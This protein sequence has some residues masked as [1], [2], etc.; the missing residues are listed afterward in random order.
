MTPMNVSILVA[1]IIMMMASEFVVYH[2]DVA[3]RINDG[4]GHIER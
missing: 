2:G 4:F 1:M 3:C